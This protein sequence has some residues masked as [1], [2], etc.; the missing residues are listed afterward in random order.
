[1]K[2]NSLYSLYYKD[3]IQIENVI[4]LDSYGIYPIAKKEKFLSWIMAI[5]CCLFFVACIIAIIWQMSQLI[6]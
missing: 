6:N 5:G 3:C 4:Y 1:M 2:A